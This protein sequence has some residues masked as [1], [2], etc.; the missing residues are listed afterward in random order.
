MTPEDLLKKTEDYCASLICERDYLNMRIQEI[1]DE[2]IRFKQAA[3]GRAIRDEA[4][5]VST[6]DAYRLDILS[7]PPRQNRDNS[8]SLS[9]KSN[10][11]DADEDDSWPG[12][13]YAVDRD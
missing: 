5:N 8:D 2:L 7:T 10:V 4:P 12:T 6:E 9:P 11:F 1:N 3:D 13:C